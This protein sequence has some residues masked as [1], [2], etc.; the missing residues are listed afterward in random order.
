M[1]LLI[2]P[3]HSFIFDTFYVYKILLKEWFFSSHHTTFIQQD[4]Q[5]EI[6]VMEDCFSHWI[7]KANLTYF[8]N[9]ILSLYL[10]FWLLNSESWKVKNCEI[11]MCNPEK[12]KRSI[13][14]KIK[15]CNYNLYLNITRN[16]E[17]KKHL[18]DIISQFREKSINH[19]LKNKISIVT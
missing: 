13:I 11:W 3:F 6:N 17:R 9:L 15:S 12:K 14:C 10:T 1:Q 2:Y 4:L 5:L 7:K 16:S 19:N 8:L 18:R